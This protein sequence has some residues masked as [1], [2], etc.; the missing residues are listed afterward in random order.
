MKRTIL[1]CL[2]F[3]VLI[4]LNSS[5]VAPTV[6]SHTTRVKYL[7][8]DI[9]QMP[10]VVELDVAENPIRVDTLHVNLPFEWSDDNP[11]RDQIRDEL[12][13]KALEKYDADLLMEPK[14]ETE[15]RYE[16]LT[17][18]TKI[19]ITGYPAKYTNFRTMTM[20]DLEMLNSMEPG[21]QYRTLKLAKFWRT[22]KGKKHKKAENILKIAE[23]ETIKA[24]DLMQDG[25]KKKP[26]KSSQKKSKKK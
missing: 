18:Y 14:E 3:W 22:K 10:T 6:V 5:C 25:S 13:S 26:S 9:I 4:L 20:E 7:K 1:I 15:V 23:P 8:P 21:L 2:S 24:F 16:G 19:I 11:T 17:I 12:L